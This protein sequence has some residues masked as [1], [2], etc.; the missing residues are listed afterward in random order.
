MKELKELE[1]ILEAIHKKIDT[2]L[3]KLK[4]LKT[5]MVD[6]NMKAVP[7]SLPGKP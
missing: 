4:E 5:L 7:A 1:E 3:P 6:M 2:L